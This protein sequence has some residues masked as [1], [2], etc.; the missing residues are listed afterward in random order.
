ML[1]ILLPIALIITLISL[2]YENKNLQFYKHII[3]LLAVIFGLITFIFNLT[4]ASNSAT[5]SV[6]TI[7]GLIFTSITTLLELI[8]IFPIIL[9]TLKKFKLM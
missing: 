2:F 6:C 7:F 4:Y 8:M 9:K 1:I 5:T 3:L